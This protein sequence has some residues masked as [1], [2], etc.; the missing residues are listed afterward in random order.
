MWIQTD[1]IIMNLDAI[2]AIFIDNNNRSN[3][4]LRTKNNGG[5]YNITHETEEVAKEYYQWLSSI[6]T[7]KVKEG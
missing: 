3:I 1:D 2:E 5:I 7:A 6:L 4:L